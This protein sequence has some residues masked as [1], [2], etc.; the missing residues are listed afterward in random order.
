MVN[1]DHV[2]LRATLVNPVYLRNA[3][4]DLMTRPREEKSM[5]TDVTVRTEVSAEVVPV[6]KFKPVE[7]NIDHLADHYK[8]LVKARSDAKQLKA[9]IEALEV[10]IKQELADLGA[11]DGKIKGAVVVTH[12][13][14][15]SYRLAEFREDHPEI[16]DKYLV[17]V[18][19]LKLNQNALLVDHAG[20]LEDYRSTAFNI[21]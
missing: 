8:K 13:P 16:Y 4:V 7:A 14:K 21:K 5:S 11:T 3:M 17:P 20:M 12:R 10:M 15:E 6:R 18:T 2:A 1:Q 9:Y 19:E